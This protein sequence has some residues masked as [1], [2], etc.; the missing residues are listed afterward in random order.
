MSDR[1]NSSEENSI[2]NKLLSKKRKYTIPSGSINSNKDFSSFLDLKEF[3]YHKELEVAKN[4]SK[5]FNLPSPFFRCYEGIGSSVIKY[6]GDEYVNFSSYNYLNLNGH[7]KTISSVIDSMNEL[8]TSASA[9]R[10]VSGERSIHRKLESSIADF[11]GVED[12]IVFVS[13]HA[14]NVSTISCLFSFKDLIVYDEASHNSIIQGLKLSDAKSY[15]FKHNDFKHLDRM[16]SKYRQSYNR[17]LVV[18]EGLYSMDGDIP[19]LPEFIKIKNRYSAFLMVDEAHSLGILGKDGKGIFDHYS[20][21]ARDVDIWMGTLSK[22]LCSCGGYIAGKE[23]LVEMLKCYA[24]GFAYS[25]AISPMNAAASLSSLE[26]LKADNK[27]VKDMQKISKYFHE[28][29]SANG[30]NVGDSIG[31][32]I[33]PVIFGKTKKT[34]EVSDALFRKYKINVNPIIHPA[35]EEKKAR[36]R[37]F[38][39]STHTK[40]QIDYTVQALINET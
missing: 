40:D 37:F 26:L 25:V 39:N 16:L 3:D 23:D 4:A 5:K 10:I 34:I 38:M 8:G 18:I 27:P 22:T 33:I 9:S 35:V 24:P 7:E 28:Q 15:A 1:K 32:G 36:L 6:N 30:F 20:I 17:V 2:F 29:L 12:S 19:N 13:G 14:T 11:Y 21:D 31:A